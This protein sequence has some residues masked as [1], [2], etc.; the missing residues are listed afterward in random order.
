MPVFEARGFTR[1]PVS[2]AASYES[3]GMRA[4]KLLLSRLDD[5][6]RRDYQATDGRQLF[7]S[8]VA[9]AGCTGSAPARAVLETCAG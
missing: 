4:E 3:P 9:G 5:S 1:R 2:R 7:D 6:Q 8:V